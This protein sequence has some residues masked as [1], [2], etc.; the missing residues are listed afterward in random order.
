MPIIVD[1]QNFVSSKDEAPDGLRAEVGLYY[2]PPVETTYPSP[3]GFRSFKT[4]IDKSYATN[5]RTD[6]NT[7]IPV[8][9]SIVL[10]SGKEDAFRDQRQ[11]RDYVNSL[12]S[13]D[14]RLFDHQCDLY[15]PDITNSFSKNY[16]D[17][18]YEDLTKKY[19]SNLLLNYNLISYPHKEK[20]ET[21]RKI[22]D[23]KTRF[24]DSSGFII[25]SKTTLGTA[26]KQFENRVAN[27]SGSVNE[28]MVKQRNIFDLQKSLI[29]TRGESF[30][31]PPTLSSVSFPYFYKKSL[32]IMGD[33]FN[34]QEF[35]NILDR[36]G[37]TKNILQSI[38][39]DLSAMV[40][41]FNIGSTSQQVKLYDLISMITS[42]SVLTTV[43]Q[44][45]ETFLVPEDQLGHGKKQNRFLEKLSA[46]RLLS[47]MRKFIATHSR[48]IGEIYNSK[49][50]K[51]FFLGYRIEKYLDNDATQPVQ[52]YYTN[53]T[54]FIDTQ[55]KYGR[56]YIYKTKALLGVL[57]SSY[58]YSNLFIS[59]DD[60]VM[61]NGTGESPTMYPPDFGDVLNDKYKAYAEVEIIPSFKIIELEVDKDEVSFVDSPTLPPQVDVFNRK[62]KPHIEVR[63]SPNFFTVESVSAGSNKELMRELSP[64]TDDD[65]VTSELLKLSK[66]KSVSPDYFTGIYEIYRTTVPPKF[67]KDFEDSY[68]ATVDDKTGY[69]FPKTNLP[70]TKLDNMV[71][72]F[73]DNV[74]VNKKYYYAFRSMTYHGTPSNLSIPLE[75]ELQKDSDE[76]KLVAKKHNYQSEKYY[77][78]NKTAKRILKV[79]PNIDRLLFSEEESPSKWAL[80]NGSLLSTGTTRTFKIRVTSKHTGKKI[81]LNIN[82]KLSK[83]DSF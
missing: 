53:D 54:T 42:T 39:A 56:R 82:F 45:D 33:N 35:K 36:T 50:S 57:G 5:S 1:A 34:N 27:Y 43:E 2:S 12:I 18:N 28:V 19:D 6:A 21:V 76:Y 29:R 7:M 24:D 3:S 70:E 74:L 81:D 61:V 26:M 47:E 22:G 59:D 71:G 58:S 51:T 10:F 83:D 16:H 69:S 66:D 62:D 80:D 11:W 55:L 52:T 44:S 72:Y 68:L 8:K 40:R 64:L 60:N 79:T 15:Y 75:I 20:S 30:N 49:N 65:Y 78:F 14:V 31:T 46:V 17:P 23:I 41:D 63:L 9:K 13:E 25:Q 32:P 48:D 4:N 37:K 38:K 67:E 73:K 77:E